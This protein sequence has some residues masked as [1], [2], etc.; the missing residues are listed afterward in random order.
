MFLLFWCGLLDYGGDECG[1]PRGRIYVVLY[2]GGAMLGCSFL[3]GVDVNVLV[4]EDDF[5][6][7]ELLRE[8]FE[9]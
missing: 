4:V 2:I 8:G 3:F 9:R 7:V 6:I 5:G 1:S